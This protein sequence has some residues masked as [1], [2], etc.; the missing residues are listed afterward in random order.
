[1]TSP[2]RSVADEPV[3]VIGSGP[4]GAVAAAQLVRRGVDVLMLDSGVRAPHGVVVKAA[5]HTVLRYRQWA[6]INGDRLASGSSDDIVWYSSLSNGGLS[7]YWTAA[8]PRFAPD[9]FTEGGRLDERYVWPV[10]YD[11]VEPF[12]VLAEQ[13][14][15]VTAGDPIPGVPSNSL[16]HR[17]AL[18]RDWQ[19]VVER[20]KSNGSGLGAIPLAKGAP[21][22]IALRPA[23]FVS[24]Q[25]VVRPLEQEPKFQI[26]HG[27]HV[28][29]L[30]WSSSKHR[31]HEVEYVDRVT[32]VRHVVPVRAVVVAAGTI[33]T[34]MLL[35]RSTSTDFPDGLGNTSGLVG[36]YL[37]DHPREWWVARSDRRMRTL[38]HPVYLARSPVEDSAPLMATSHTFGRASVVDSL[39]NSF[40]GTTAIGVQVFGTMVPQPE[41]S[42]SV[43]RDDDPVAQRPTISLAYDDAAVANLQSSRE[44]LRSVLGDAG[45]EIEV[46]GPFHD[47]QPG[48]SV[49]YS[50]TVRMHDDPQFGVLDRWN[51]MHD[52]P[53]VVV[54]DMSAFPTG[55]EKN[56]T[57]TAMALAIRAADRLADQLA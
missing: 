26:R 56:P 24:Y 48:S 55:P 46:A 14:L 30:N 23:E 6:D 12:Y 17:Q 28:T 36:R 47:P 52:A 38:L 45:L 39:R 13:H 29:R 4:S 3:V 34:T 9:D 2:E 19:A 41:F 10:T 25:C 22:M 27:A 42:V 40:R 1:M 20:G 53:D 32:G 43:N 21:W 49:H 7:N 16:R 37:H 11:D 18:P 57:L 33:D 50:G 35:L 5:G 8:V 51:R 44:R 15:R 54:C 31:V